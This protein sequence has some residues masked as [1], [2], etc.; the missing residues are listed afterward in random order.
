MSWRQDLLMRLQK[1]SENRLWGIK[2]RCRYAVD[3]RRV[4]VS[5]YVYYRPRLFSFPFFLL[6]KQQRMRL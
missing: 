2:H 1:N 6:I 3:C 5:N 4:I